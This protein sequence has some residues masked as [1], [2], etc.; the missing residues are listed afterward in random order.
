MDKFEKAKKETL[1]Y[2]NGDE[3][4]T[5]VFLT[6]YALRGKDGVLVENTPDDM[7]DRLAKEFAR[8]EKKFGG[9]R[10]LSYEAIRKYLNNVQQ[11]YK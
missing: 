4:A 7:H 2:F 8:I 3:L 5:N 11:A 9:S 6:K 1:E 10:A